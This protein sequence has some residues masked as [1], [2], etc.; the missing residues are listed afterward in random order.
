MNLLAV[1]ENE[2]NI[3]QIIPHWNVF[4]ITVLFEVRTVTNCNSDCIVVCIVETNLALSRENVRCFR[5]N[6][7]QTGPL[8]YQHKEL[9]IAQ[10]NTFWCPINLKTAKNKHADEQ[11][12]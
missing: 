10:R 9:N 12:D 6:Q 1:F 3:K 5:Q 4:M 2:T 8:T 11:T 7:K